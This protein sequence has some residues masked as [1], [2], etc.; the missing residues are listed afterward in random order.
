LFNVGEVVVMPDGQV[1]ST[2]AI[3]KAAEMKAQR[4]IEGAIEKAEN[5]RIAAEKAKY[6]EEKLQAKR[7][8]REPPPRPFFAPT[9]SIQSAASIYDVGEAAGRDQQPPKQVLRL[10]KK[11]QRRQEML[12]PK[13]V[14]P[15]PVIPEG[16]SL[17][18]GEENL[19]VLWDITDEE[20]RRRLRAKKKEKIQ[21][22][23]NLRRI[24]KEQKKFNR[25]M[26][27]RKKQAAN[28][29]V[30][31]DPEKAKKEI[32]GEMEKADWGDHNSDS[33]SE[34]DSD[35]DSDFDSEAETN[36]KKE[37]KAGSGDNEDSDSSSDSDSNSDTDSEAEAGKETPK[38]KKKGMPQ[39][40]RPRLDLD[41]LEQAARINQDQEDKKR[42]ARLRRRAERREAAAKDAAKKEAEAELA[43]VKAEQE[44]RAKKQISFLVEEKSS[45]KRKRSKEEEPKQNGK[46]I[47]SEDVE[48]DEEAQRKSEKKERR[49][50]KEKRREEKAGKAAKGLETFESTKVE[51][52]D[53]NLDRATTE[54]EAEL[55]AKNK[56]FEEERPQYTKVA[57]Q[58]NPEALTG[59]EERKQKFLRLLGGGKQ[60]ETESQKTER[61]ESEKKA[62]KRERKAAR[63]TEES[64]EKAEQIEK[65]QSD[66][67]KQYE[68]GMKLKHEG[69]GHRR[70]LGA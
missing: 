17:P 65:M 14:P 30:L 6:K 21:A 52:K 10:S 62:A 11:Q 46:K 27:V 61:E 55:R 24:Q 44:E 42:N 60:K 57:Q 2:E 37:S 28:A 50:R 16:I 22:G 69:G 40:N 56:D 47:K 25:A 13:P 53:D 31:W 68:A 8:G 23:K 7:E 43:R 48:L 39:V 19:L 41:L 33:E 64:A 1:K 49:E 51:S 35:S 66:L 38:K 4:E 70:G 34:S 36:G 20:I 45:K 26:K 32:L 5:E 63:K 59:D 9:I 12:K 58:W 29:G 15:K 54:Q 18:A 67:V 3:K